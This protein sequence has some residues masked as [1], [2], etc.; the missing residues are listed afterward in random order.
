M[1]LYRILF[2][3]ALVT[4]LSCSHEMEDP[5]GLD[6]IPA[7]Q[8]EVDERPVTEIN[9][10]ILPI[11]IE[12]DT[13]TSVTTSGK[14]SWVAN[15][16][17]GF[18]PDAQDVQYGSPQQSIFYVS[19]SS[20]GSPNA[21]F[22]AN[23]WGLLRGKKYYSYYPYNSEATSTSVDITYLGQNQTSN[24]S[25]GNL[26]KF[27]YL[28]AAFTMPE[29][30]NQDLDYKHL[31]GIVKLVL[32]FG[33]EYASS[34]F[35]GMTLTAPSAI[36]VESARYNPSGTAVTY[37]STVKKASLSMKLNSGNGFKANSSYQLTLYMM[38][39]PTSWKDKAM[40]V[41]VQ[42]SDGKEFSGKFTPTSNLAAGSGSSFSVKMSCT[43]GVVDLGK[44]ETANCYIVSRAGDY[45]FKTVKGN[46]TISVGTVASVKVLWESV[47]TATAPT[48][49]SVIKSVSYS[50][51]YITFSTPAT[52]K[53]GNAL[54]AACNSS[55]TILWS[56]HI[57]CTAEPNV[58][59]YQN[60]AGY[61]MD[62]NLGA[63]SATGN[64]SAG[65][66]YQWGRKDPFPG[67]ASISKKTRMATT[68]TFKSVAVSSSNGSVAWATKNP[69]TFIYCAY[70]E[71]HPLDWSWSKEVTERTWR[72]EAGAKTKY[73]PCPPGY[74][75][76][77]G[78]T[79]TNTKAGRGFWGKALGFN[80]RVETTDYIFITPAGNA[81]FSSNSL[82]LPIEGGKYA[83]YPATGCLNDSDGTFDYVGD[84]IFEWTDYP[85]GSDGTNWNSQ[86]S[87]VLDVNVPTDSNGEGYMTVNWN[88]GR[89][90]GKS[91]RCELIKMD[92]TG[93]TKANEAFV[94]VDGSW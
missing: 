62:R 16:K 24:G 82:S 29:Q 22:K 52:F 43:G 10:N 81:T 46:T 78:S 30:G 35:T 49:G 18:W 60:S 93:S 21:T 17:L 56:W 47:G 51:N 72:G 77:S 86:Y 80:Y 33:S 69:T 40:T 53:K 70:S 8:K 23:G 87:S 76:P 74:K 85:G 6:Q 4:V 31:G 91:V 88:S 71:D 36:L 92:K 67:T 15:D 27:D 61:L 5:A 42:S 37:N 75:V 28:H 90:C 89:S 57:W 54:I 48:V 59:E 9:V 94:S 44:N 41:T 63:L 2:I 32:T 73:D 26:G 1:K 34:V 68:A 20:D 7:D 79:T 84:H 58:E 45:K 3:S 55:G 25:S 64:L 66:F 50:N 83:Y 39:N 38:M 11:E 14:F 12:P 65:L 13:K 19:E